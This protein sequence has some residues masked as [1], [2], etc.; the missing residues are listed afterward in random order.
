[1]KVEPFE[2]KDYEQ[3]VEEEQESEEDDDFHFYFF[4]N[5][6]KPSKPSHSKD[7]LLIG[8]D[9]LP[10]INIAAKKGI[11]CTCKKRKKGECECFVKLPCLCGAKQKAECTCG[12]LSNICICD[13][14]PKPV[15]ECEKA[16]VCACCNLPKPICTCGDV[17]KPCVCYPDKFPYPVCVCKSKPKFG[18]LKEVESIPSFEG[19]FF[20]ED[21]GRAG[22]PEGEAEQIETSKVRKQIVKTV[23]RKMKKYDQ[24]N[25]RSEKRS[26]GSE[27][28]T[29]EFLEEIIVEEG[30]EE[31]TKEEGGARK[32]E[33]EG[34]EYPCECQK[35]D[36]KKRCFCLKGKECIC[37]KY[38]CICGVQ[39]TCVCEPEDSVDS[40]YKSDDSPSICSCNI[41]RVCNCEKEGVECK[42]FPPKAVCTCKNPNKCKCMKVCD[43]V[44][45]CICDTAA[46]KIEECICLDKAKQ[47]EKGYICTCPPPD[48]ASPTV[49]KK[50]RAGKHGYRWCHDVDPKNTF[51]DY[52]YDRYDK[53][54]PKKQQEEKFKILGLYDEIKRPDGVC[55]VHG[56]KLPRFKKKRFR[57]P[58][59]DCCSA[60]G[61]NYFKL[62]MKIFITCQFDEYDCK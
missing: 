2:I 25:E 20:G 59:V 38:E 44:Y 43:C 58:S 37:S 29:E 57:K 19:E 41:A 40:P 18:F 10:K 39:K 62:Q 12:K 15:C 32:V 7:S 6:T 13:E 22:G 51:F 52:A 9:G 60:V 1:M 21:E 47:I 31:S 53:I 26:E 54:C 33:E 34:K 17:E 4:P 30:I 8:P 5:C 11:V 27:Q 46:A 48:A 42:C 24:S 49:I 28:G 23:V 16:M 61:G 55:P 14:T 56:L 3:A 36:P 35:P 45:P 50:V